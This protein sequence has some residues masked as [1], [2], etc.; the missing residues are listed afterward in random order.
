MSR[1]PD[2]MR[3]TERG[4]NLNLI[5]ARLTICEQVCS[6]LGTAERGQSSLST[7]PDRLGE[8]TCR[9]HVKPN[10]YRRQISIF[11]N[12]RPNA[13]QRHPLRTVECL[14]A[15]AIPAPRC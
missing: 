2:W 8:V 7:L 5:I 3:K 15:T 14:D 9:S 13:S 11:D 12:Q 4:S 6:E 10:G 1:S